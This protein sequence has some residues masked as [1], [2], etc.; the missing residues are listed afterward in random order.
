MSF[1]S[2]ELAAIVLEYLAA[3]GFSKTFKQF[4]K[5]AEGLLNKARVRELIAEKGSL[6]N[7]LNEYLG[8]IESK[9]KRERLA[10]TNGLARQMYAALESEEACT[11][12]GVEGRHYEINER[13]RS[14]PN[15]ETLQVVTPE[16]Q[17]IEQSPAAYRSVDSQRPSS[18]RNLFG[19]DPSP[20]PQVGRKKKGTPRKRRQM[21]I[22]FLQRAEALE[23]QPKAVT[24][25]PVKNS[26]MELLFS[27]RDSKDNESDSSLPTP[28]FTFANEL[29]S[30][31][32]KTRDDSA[33]PQ[34]A[35]A[36]ANVGIDEFETYNKLSDVAV[37]EFQEL[38]SVLDIP[39]EPSKGEAD[40]DGKYADGS[41]PTVDGVDTQSSGTATLKGKG[42]ANKSL[43][44]YLQQNNSSAGNVDN[45][46]SKIKYSK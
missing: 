20:S 1:E 27:N 31:I 36:N 28:V 12:R 16:R 3:E 25:S 45:F 39:I 38:F 9:R 10:S 23:K 13:R 35:H 41:S 26:F 37:D 7:V 5:E 19:K 18:N 29:A 8:L 22:D 24:E 46:L 21:E 34:Q 2:G 43:V 15:A 14:A 11:S 17:F 4:Q 42:K 44:N 40:P 32:N 33:L 6:R 30:R